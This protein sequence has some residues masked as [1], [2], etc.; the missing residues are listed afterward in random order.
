MRRAS[1]AGVGFAV[2][3]FAF[4]GVLPIYFKA[5]VHVPPLEVLAH[6]VVWSI[7]ILVLFVSLTRGWHG[8][9]V[10]LRGRRTQCLLLAS[11]LLLSVNW[12]AFIWAIDRG[13]ILE[14]SLGYYI[15]PL[16]NVFLGVVVLRERLG[17]LRGGAVGLAALGVLNLVFSLGALP[18]VS[19]ILAGSFGVYGLIR[20]TVPLGAAQGLFAETMLLLPFAVSYLVV[21]GAVG[22]GAFAASDRTTD[23]LLLLAGVATAT[24][25]VAFAAGARRLDYATV[26]IFQYIAPTGHFLLAVYV[27]GETFTRAHM[28]TFA[29]IWLALAIYSIQLVRTVDRTA[30]V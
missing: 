17:L 3:A 27:Y 5:V 7:P 14:I 20:K 11:T 1:L 16:V 23:G 4:W 29:L 24:P 13:R 30:K 19:L 9:A 26:G 25:L 15:N 10:A 28:V 18:W 8:M 12:L 21:L 6:R 2:S 22:S